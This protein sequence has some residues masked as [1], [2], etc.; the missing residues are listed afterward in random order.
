[1]S[2]GANV[3]VAEAMQV[4]QAEMEQEIRGAWRAGYDY[5]HVF[6]KN[7]LYDGVNRNDPTVTL[8][9]YTYPSNSDNPTALEHD[10]IVY[11]YSYDFDSIPDHVIRAMLDQQVS[12]PV[13]KSDG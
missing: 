12:V 13:D 1:M 2:N 4:L 5:L 10:G 11:C 7:P 8:T 3:A 6:E 9:R